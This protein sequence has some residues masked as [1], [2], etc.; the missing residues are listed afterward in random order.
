MGGMNLKKGI[1]VFLAVILSLSVACLPVSAAP[2]FKDIAGHWCEKEVGQASDLGFIDGYPDGTMRPDNKV[3][4]AEFLKMVVA[5]NKMPLADARGHDIPF[6]DVLGHWFLP[7]LGTGVGH[8]IIRPAEYTGRRYQPDSH[9][10]RDEAAAYVVRALGLSEEA[11]AKDPAE[12]P[13]SDMT[14]VR[15]VYRGPVALCAELG[16]LKGYEDGTIRGNRTLTRAEAVV[17]VLRALSWKGSRPRVSIP[18]EKYQK[19]L[20]SVKGT[21][22]TY[23]AGGNTVTTTIDREAGLYYSKTCFKLKCGSEEHKYPDWVQT[24]GY[25]DS[26]VLTMLYKFNADRAGLIP[27]MAALPIYGEVTEVLEKQP[28]H[29]YDYASDYTS[30]QE[31]KIRGE[32][33]GEARGPY[34]REEGGKQYLCK[35]MTCTWE[36]SASNGEK[37]DGDFSVLAYYDPVSGSISEAHLIYHGTFE[38]SKTVVSANI[39]V[40]RTKLTQSDDYE[41]NPF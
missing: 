28:I 29:S 20:Y 1:S 23:T 34:W 19:A 40:I 8:G 22:Q 7:Y 10:T 31:V 21:I 18:L 35:E 6:D 41:V 13:F 24:P 16:I 39:Q 17:M 3:T 9:I 5:G 25:Y 27:L 38:H 32:L 4:R 26:S 11:D 33:L 14:S 37:G 15:D 30:G 2:P 36:Y 12:A